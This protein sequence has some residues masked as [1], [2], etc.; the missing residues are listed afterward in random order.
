[1]DGGYLLNR[2][3][4]WCIPVVPQASSWRGYDGRGISFES[5]CCCGASQW[6]HKQAHVALFLQAVVLLAQISIGLTVYIILEID[7]S[8]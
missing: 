2:A 6:S 8:N 1:M 7:R 4:L 5:S 3:L